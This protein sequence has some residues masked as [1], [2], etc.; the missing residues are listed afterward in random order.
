[1]PYDYNENAEC[2]TILKFLHDASGGNKDVVYFL[3][4]WLAGLLR[5]RGSELQI[6]LHLLGEAGTGKGTFIRLCSELV[7]SRNIASTSMKLMETDKFET[8][9]YFNKRLIVIADNTSFCG[10]AEVFN[11]LTGGDPIR[12]ERKR[13]Q[14]KTTF[15]FNGMVLVASNEHLQTSDKN[16]GFNRRR[17]TVRFDQIATAEQKED[18]AKKGGEAAVLHSEMAGLVNWLLELSHSDIVHAM[19]NPPECVLNENLDAMAADNP[20]IDWFMDLVI[21]DPT[22]KTPF[23]CSIKRTSSGAETTFEDS[24][25]KLYPSYLL[26][27]QRHNKFPISWRVFRAKFMSVAKTLH[28]DIV[29][30]R[31]RV[32]SWCVLGIAIRSEWTER[33]KW[34]L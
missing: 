12:S 21:P 19:H 29:E 34:T 33:H 31:D 18:W 22:A 4:A 11:N 1:L 16:T 32:L 7:G 30:D 3:R 27:C 15:I 28:A 10:G 23:G 25:T 9:S 6:F 13:V 20:L 5:G 17:R 2:P 26:Y 8:E 14:K 24:D